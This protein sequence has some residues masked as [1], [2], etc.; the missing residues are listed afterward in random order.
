MQDSQTEFNNI[1]YDSAYPEGIEHHYWNRARNSI[2]KSALRANSLTKKKILEIGCGRGLVVESLRT[3]GYECFGVDTA[4]I[5]T[6]REYLYF[7][8]DFAELDVSLRER[9]EVIL[10]LD[11]IEHIPNAEEFLARIHQV[12]P[13][14]KHILITVPARQELWSNYD[15]YYGHVVRYTRDSLN[16]TIIHAGYRILST[17]Y[18]FHVLYIPA[19][20]LAFFKQKRG[21]VVQPPKGVMRFIHRLIAFML[22]MEQKMLPQRFIGT[23]LISVSERIDI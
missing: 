12:F 16:Q 9:I 1:Q 18:F 13:Q 6:K 5:D 7:G 10:L 3:D 15:K 20:I 14:A 22:V 21:I 8:V 19:Y 17:L 2:I 23:S 4:R 11:V